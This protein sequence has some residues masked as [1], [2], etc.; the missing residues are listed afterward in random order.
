MR[1]AN[2]IKTPLE[3]VPGHA[4][5]MEIALGKGV[6][7]HAHVESKMEKDKKHAT[8]QS[9]RTIMLFGTCG[10]ETVAEVLSAFA[11]FLRD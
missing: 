8:T 1:A 10:M 6:T 4:K 3:L 2:N 5:T 9:M 11:A 7:S